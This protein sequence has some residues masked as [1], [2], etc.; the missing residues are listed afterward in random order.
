MEVRLSALS[1]GHPLPP[2]RLL[3]IIS[4]RGR[5]DPRAILRLEWL[6][7]LKKF[8]NFIGNRTRDLP[9]CSTVPQTTTLPRAPIIILH[10][11]LW[12]SVF[13]LRTYVTSPTM[14]SCHSSCFPSARCVS[15]ANAVCNYI[16]ICINSRSNIHNLN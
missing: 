5:V 1:A 8:N 14:F 4:V 9:A 3:V 2:G 6:G 7:Q 15:A 11:L 10:Y 16:D 12:T 13:L